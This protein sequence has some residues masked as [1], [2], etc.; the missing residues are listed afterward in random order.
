MTPF[1][2]NYLNHQQSKAKQ[3]ENSNVSEEKKNVWK[4]GLFRNEGAVKDNIFH[5]ANSS[6]WLCNE[7]VIAQ[8]TRCK[9]VQ[10]KWVI[11]SFIHSTCIYCV[12]CIC[13]LYSILHAIKWG[14]WC[15]TQQNSRQKIWV[16][17]KV[18]G[19]KCKYILHL[20]VMSHLV[21]WD[22]LMETIN[23][24]ILANLKAANLS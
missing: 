8:I 1:E 14:Q 21:K 24:C 7:A 6:K 9:S 5:Q 13:L 3:N 4:L 22:F 23:V 12:Y 17:S 19:L 11:L 18:K 15:D 16:I 20:F 2:A 10:V